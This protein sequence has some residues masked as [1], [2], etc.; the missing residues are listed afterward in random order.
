ML[1]PRYRNFTESVSDFNRMLDGMNK[2]QPLEPPSP[3]AR[4][5]ALHE[6]APAVYQ[7]DAD[8]RELLDNMWFYMPGGL[9]REIHSLYAEEQ[10]LADIHEK[11]TS[12]H[13]ALN[14]VDRV[15]IANRHNKMVERYQVM[16]N[17]FARISHTAKSEAE[18]RNYGAMCEASSRKSKL[19]GRHSQG[20]TH[21]N[22]MTESQDPA[23]LSQ[24]RNGRSAIQSFRVLA[25]LDEQTMMPRDPG[26]FGTTRFNAGYDDMTYVE[27]EQSPASL[28]EDC[29]GY[30]L[31]RFGSLSEGGGSRRRKQ[32]RQDAMVSKYY[33]R[34]TKMPKGDRKP[35]DAVTAPRSQQRRIERMAARGGRPPGKFSD[36]LAVKSYAR[37]MARKKKSIESGDY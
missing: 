36:P 1:K 29:E 7:A 6:S 26:L 18:R 31:K 10:A 37:K 20:F 30:A 19:H 21:G 5:R 2:V 28:N 9:K 24:Y 16:S 12:G 4:E 23:Y 15:A 27:D 35:A 3:A 34:P 25:G 8:M 22:A 13:I 17:E 33:G 32:A 14:E 11:V